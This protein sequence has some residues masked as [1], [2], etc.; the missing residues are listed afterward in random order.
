MQVSEAYLLT[1]KAR[2]GGPLRAT[3]SKA[4]VA[5]A[6][7]STAMKPRVLAI[8][9]G[10]PREVASS[11]A[12]ERPNLNDFGSAQVKSAKWLFELASKLWDEVRR[13]ASYPFPAVAFH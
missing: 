4:V 13:V 11:A 8:E 10:S 12:D 6:A 1:Q 9:D 2:S 7:V 5:S 3:P